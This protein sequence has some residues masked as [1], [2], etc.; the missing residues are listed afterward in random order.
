M[1]TI[2]SPCVPATSLTEDAYINKLSSTL[3]F[4]L[5]SDVVGS[6]TERVGRRRGLHA[7]LAHA[8]VGE[9]AVTVGV[10]QNVVQLQVTATTNDSQH[11]RR[12][13]T[14]PLQ[15]LAAI[16]VYAA[17]CWVVHHTAVSLLRWHHTTTGPSI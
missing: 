2:L 1:C 16:T 4:N 13:D 9:L 5:W 12:N 17:G 15:S 11:V 3:I 6:A 8:K 10:Q 14:L 7:F